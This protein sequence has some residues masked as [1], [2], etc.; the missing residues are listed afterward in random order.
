MLVVEERK[1]RKKRQKIQM[2]EAGGVCSQMKSEI[3]LEMLK[4]SYS[5]M[6]AGR[7]LIGDLK[8][9]GFKV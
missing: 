9:R 4:H 1:L 6:T 2:G 8:V 3:N 5:S 7:S